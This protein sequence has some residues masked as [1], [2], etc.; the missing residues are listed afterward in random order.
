M[1]YLDE[2]V[3]LTDYSILISLYRNHP[4]HLLSGTLFAQLVSQTF[5]I[6]A[7]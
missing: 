6:D 7:H 5:Q 1:D 2:I 4:V 3:L